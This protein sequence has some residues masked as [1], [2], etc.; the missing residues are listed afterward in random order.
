MWETTINDGI[1]WLIIGFIFGLALGSMFT[2]AL[3][4]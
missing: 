4:K 2:M 3:K 1:G